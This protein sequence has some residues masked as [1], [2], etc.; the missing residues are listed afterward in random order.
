[1][2]CCCPFAS[3][4]IFKAILKDFEFAVD[5][6]LV[7]FLRLTHNNLIQAKNMQMYRMLSNASRKNYSREQQTAAMGAVIS[8]HE[9]T[10]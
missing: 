3:E 10:C 9:E 1:M 5:F 7:S 8:Y 4:M 6:T 2:L